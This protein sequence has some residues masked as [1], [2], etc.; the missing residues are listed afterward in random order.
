M[1]RIFVLCLLCLISFLSFSQKMIDLEK[2]KFSS[3]ST[4]VILENNDT[5]FLIPQINAGFNG[6]QNGWNQWVQSNINKSVVANNGAPIGSYMV[7]SLF[8][9]EKD[10]SINDIE[11]TND[12]GYGTA[13]ELIR[14]LKNSPKWD[15]AKKNGRSVKCIRALNIPF[16]VNEKWDDSDFIKAVAN[17][18]AFK[19]VEIQAEFPGGTDGWEKY[20]RKNLNSFVALDNNAPNGIYTVEVT[21]IVDKDGN[22]T[23]VKAL[24]TPGYGTTEEVI[25]VIKN[26]PKWRPGIQNGKIVKSWRTQK[27]SFSVMK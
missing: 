23:D 26:G 8:I 3:D 2:A 5:V 24:T 9:V 27:V 11:I 18:S 17:D 10:G 13:Q 14:V 12:P 16:F 4:F 7:H 1:R 6:G 25:R 20:L 21:F 19:D 15:P 22:I